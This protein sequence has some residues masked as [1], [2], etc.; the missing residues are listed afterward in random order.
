MNNELRH[1]DCHT[2]QMGIEPSSRVHCLALPLNSLALCDIYIAIHKDASKDGILISVALLRS[3]IYPSMLSA[4]HPEFGP[5]AI[6]AALSL[7]L[8]LPW[9]WRARNVATLS[10]IGW[11]FVSNIIY[12]VDA[13]IWA[14][15]IVVVVP[16][17]CDIS[18]PSSISVGNIYWTLALAT[19]LIIGANFALPAAC[20]CICIH[21]EQVASL[22]LAHN[23][24]S[25][26]QRRQFFEVGMC[27]GLPLIFMALRKLLSYVASWS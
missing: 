6:L 10:M 11:L 21:L 15:N 12:A 23:T 9:H 4:V 26:R 17:W 7:F 27:L 14:N 20:L 1:C 2:F 25:D 3:S 5:V 24:L 8:P 13:F 22:R 19:K 16:V 18:K